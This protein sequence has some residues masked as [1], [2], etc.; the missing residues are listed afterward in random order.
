MRI[1]MIGASG[2]V[3][4]YTL[5]EGLART[6]EFEFVHPRTDD[7]IFKTEYNKFWSLVN[8]SLVISSLVFK[9]IIHPYPIGKSQLLITN[10]SLLI[11][12]GFSGSLIRQ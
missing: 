7:I 8:W 1:A 5:D 3:P 11:A 6:L 9:S 10:S 12:Q 2:F 4:P